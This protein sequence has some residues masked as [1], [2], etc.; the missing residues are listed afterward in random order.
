MTP[1]RSDPRAQDEA[2]ARDKAELARRMNVAWPTFHDALKKMRET[3][4]AHPFWRKAVGTP[5]ENDMPVRAAEVALAMILN[6]T[7]ARAPD[8]GDRHHRAK[9]DR[10]GG[11]PLSDA[12]DLG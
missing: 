10:M 12:T 1:T 6:V 3:M 2:R 11:A 9:L 5:L 7:E 8:Q 4:E